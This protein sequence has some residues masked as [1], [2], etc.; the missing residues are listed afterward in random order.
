MSASEGIVGRRLLHPLHLLSLFDAF[1][2]SSLSESFDEELYV[3]VAQH[4]LISGKAR[5]GI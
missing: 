2:G 4:M 3:Q 1:L 5:N